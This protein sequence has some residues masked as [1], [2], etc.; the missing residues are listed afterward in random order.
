MTTTDPTPNSW[1]PEADSCP[2]LVLLIDDQALVAAA[3]ARA[4]ADEPDV[5]MHYCGNP[6]EAVLAA[7]KLK[8]TVILLDLVMPQA[9][10]AT[11]L[12]KFRANPATAHTPIVILSTKEE[13][14]VKSALFAAGANDYMVKL[15][16]R[17]ELLARIRYHSA[18]CWHRIQRD[19][20]FDALRRSQQALVD[21]N[22]ALLAAN[23]QLGKAAQAK[24]D[25]LAS[26]SHELRTPMNGVI[27]VA[28]LLLD[29][30][31]SESQRDYVETVRGSA[32]ALV[33]LVNDILDFSKME[34]RKLALECVDF[35]LR[36]VVEGV[37]KL[38]GG[39][40]NEKGIHLAGIIPTQAPTRLRGDPTR[41]RQILTN[42]VGNALKFTEQGAVAVRVAPLSESATE[43][44]LCLEVQDTGIGIS[45]EAQRRLFQPFSQ[46]DDSTSR[47]F[48][49]TGL[50]LAICRELVELMGGHIGLETSEGKGSTF[51]FTMTLE[52]QPSAAEEPAS[53]SRWRAL[54]VAE[55]ALMRSLVEQEVRS[56]GLRSVGAPDLR[57]AGVL[58]REPGDAPFDFV[59]VAATVEE[60]L[61]LGRALKAANRSLPVV[62]LA[63]KGCGVIQSEC[64]K[65]GVDACLG[66]P[67]C[68]DDFW[69]SVLPLLDPQVERK[70]AVASAS[71]RPAV[72]AGRTV[73]VVD[74]HP[75]NQMVA[76]GLLKKWGCVATAAGD[77][78]AALNAV[79]QAP[80]DVILMDRELPGGDGCETVRLIREFEHA[81][82]RTPC[83][84][85][86]MTAHVDEAT[87]KECLA[88]GMDAFL[89][90]P[91][92]ESALRAALDGGGGC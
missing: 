75:V 78:D 37:L 53:A 70:H 30:P 6:L 79:R 62:L 23:E 55:N 71:A 61:A 8:P 85:V 25:F 92:R 89:S 42:L 11:L 51:R 32:E 3:V 46:A 31:L 72:S 87:R 9:D 33:S 56:F 77:G 40:A 5:E 50:G 36:E 48:G 35:D 64:G 27:G 20:A 17:L 22:T 88:A 83:R 68:R 82:G 7:N 39:I 81:A 44:T 14:E 29:T 12:R 47:R 63:V 74:D 15:P 91:V 43:A 52:K 18:A 57:T 21:S 26:M 13:P 16:D 54:I 4:V 49:G 24:S 65:C 28:G 45:P 2:A 90:K 59:L 76:L 73:L 84:I 41:L 60:G 58:L 67:L 19:E 66:S 34:A 69:E 38:M 80:F 10:G 86:A 1:N